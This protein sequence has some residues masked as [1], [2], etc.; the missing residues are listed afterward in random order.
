MDAAAVV[1]GVLV[2]LV[3]LADAADTLVSTRLRSGRWWPTEVFYRGSWK[4]WRGLSR[5]VRRDRAREQFLS[6]FGPLSL[7]VLLGL[8]TAG[9]ILGWSLVWWGLRGSFVDPPTHWVD[10]VYYSGVVYFSVGFGDVLPGS[11]A[12][13]LLSIAEAFTGL[14]LLGLVIGFLPSLYSAYQQREAQL[15]LLDDLTEHRILAVNLAASRVVDGDTHRLESFFE[16]WERWTAEVLET[17]MTFPMLMLFRSQRPGQSW[18]TAMGVVADAAA[19]YVGAV[20]GTDKSA[21]RFMHRRAALCLRTLSER[22]GVAPDFTPRITKDMWRY[23]YDQLEPL[24]L[25]LR[26]FEE[27]WERVEALRAEHAPWMEGLIEALDAPRGFWGH[28]VDGELA[29]PADG[30]GAGPGS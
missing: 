16:E 10:T 1:V 18:V 8:W 12:V 21:A 14:G 24:G 11:G 15:A 4:L 9:A 5:G 19:G 28:T 6:L 30:G 17:H 22:I 23:G 7:L 20:P 26:P 25:P 2:V 13:R 27:T 3:V 29:Q